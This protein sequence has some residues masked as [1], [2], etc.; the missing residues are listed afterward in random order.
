VE[1]FSLAP[2]Q[3]GERLKGFF[4]D[5]VVEQTMQGIEGGTSWA[6]ERTMDN[7]LMDLA[8]QGG[9]EIF[10]IGPVLGYLLAREAEAKAI[11]LIMVGKLNRLPQDK[12]RERLR[13]M[14]V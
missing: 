10:T 4:P 3:V 6:L 5:Q 8:R 14:Y 12:I 2:S 11:R 1:C 9:N 13:D 7:R